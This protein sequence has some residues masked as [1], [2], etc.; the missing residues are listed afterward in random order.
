MKRRIK[1]NHITQHCQKQNQPI[2]PKTEQM[3]TFALLYIGESFN[4][5]RFCKNIASKWIFQHSVQSDTK[6][7]LLCCPKKTD[8]SHFLLNDKTRRKLKM[9]GKKEEEEKKK[10]P[11]TYSRWSLRVFLREGSISVHSKIVRSIR[12]CSLIPGLLSF[13]P[14]ALN[15][16]LFEGC[17]YTGEVQVESSRVQNQD[18]IVLSCKMQNC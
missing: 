8:V 16:D 14:G 18:Q 6:L 15:E 17:Y 3:K 7:R 13:Y 11:F 5:K 1:Q 12:C 4:L 9:K 2:N 10:M